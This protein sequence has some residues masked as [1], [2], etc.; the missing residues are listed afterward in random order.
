MK[1]TEI[2]I[3]ILVL[4]ILSLGGGLLWFLY[5]QNQDLRKAAQTPQVDTQPELYQQETTT[6]P[7]ALQEDSGEQT[8]TE[9]EPA[10]QPA[11]LEQA[12]KQQFA[13]KFDKDTADINLE[14]NEKTSTHAEGGVT[15][16]GEMGGGWWLAATEEGKW[17]LVA[18]GNG[19][20]MCADIEPYNFPTTM[21][22]E[23]Y[24][25]DTQQLI[26]R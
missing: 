13:E 3:I 18:D 7:T 24:N 14:I 10:E 25:Q 1:T 9:P 17:V 16:T 22:P 2:I 23:C 8:P 4:A 26:K 11:P 6:K 5:Q 12:L 15:F 21:V 20:V 19:T